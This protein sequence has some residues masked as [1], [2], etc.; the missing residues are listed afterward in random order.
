[1]DY[2]EV[3][4]NSPVARRQ[5]FSYHIPPGLEVEV[6]QAVWVPFGDRQLQGVVLELSAYPAVAETRGIADIIEPCPLLSPPQAALARW[7]SDYYLSPLF[8]AVALM[9]PVGFKRSL[10]TFLSPAA[11]SAETD[12]ASLSQEQRHVL[13]LAGARGRFNLRELENTLGKKKARLITAQLVRQ[14][15]L[16]RSYELEAVRAKP[17]L[18]PYLTLAVTGE[19]ARAEVTRLL[20]RKAAKQA[21]LLD[22]LVKHDKSVSWAEARLRTN[23]D[24]AVANALV[25]K[26]LVKFQQIE[27]RRAPFSYQDITPSVPLTLT[28]AQKAALEQI[29]LSLD[30]QAKPP[31]ETRVFLLHGV[32]GSGK[33]EVYLQALAETVKRGKK[34]IVLVPEIA[35]TPQ[36]IERFAAR[37]PHRVAVLHSRLSLGEQFDEWWRIRRGEF[38]V[39]IG[40][41]YLCAPA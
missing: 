3:S 4:V 27:V 31:T 41:G 10:I 36:T 26:G 40:G 24:K 37:F 38:D 12:I 9:L 7:I 30:P 14:R 1:M 29:K 6:G 17:R 18:E 21:A 2:A 20:L 13:E 39:V 16:V 19:M 8:D 33:T 11:A 22:F 35:L 34:G 5:T 25:R 15:R 23:C 32:T 28:A